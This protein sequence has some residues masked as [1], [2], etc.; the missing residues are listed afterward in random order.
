MSKA[1]IILSKKIIEENFPTQRSA[2][3]GTYR[4]TGPEK[5]FLTT[6]NQNNVQNKEY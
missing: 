4:Y 1:Q 5:K 6:H 2:Y 3:K